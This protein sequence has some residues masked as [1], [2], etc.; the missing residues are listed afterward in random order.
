MG[1]RHYHEKMR[2]EYGSLKH[3]LDPNDRIRG[4]AEPHPWRMPS[5]SSQADLDD[6]V[7]FLLIP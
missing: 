3:G 5:G 1:E 7:G 4:S 6:L 2:R